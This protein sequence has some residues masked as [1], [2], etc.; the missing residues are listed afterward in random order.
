MWV[1][2]SILHSNVFKLHPDA[3]Q[4]VEQNESQLKL[5]TA[6]QILCVCSHPATLNLHICLLLYIIRLFGGNKKQTKIANPANYTTKYKSLWIREW[7][8]S[9]VK[10]YLQLNNTVQSSRAPAMLPQSPFILHMDAA[11]LSSGTQ[12]RR[13]DKLCVKAKKSLRSEGEPVGWGSWMFPGRSE[14][15]GQ[16][17]RIKP[18]LCSVSL[19]MGPLPQ[20]PSLCSVHTPFPD[21]SC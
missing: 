2:F 7:K 11:I 9:S 12:R 16:T 17:R 13:R 6:E 19:Y 21:A 18:G 3:I 10:Q 15:A 14:G 4:D 5:S 8:K 20:P 1:V